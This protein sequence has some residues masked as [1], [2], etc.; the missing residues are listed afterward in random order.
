LTPRVDADACPAAVEQIV[1]CA[2]N[3]RE[4]RAV[5]VANEHVAVP[6][7]TWVSTVRVAADLDIA[8]GHIVRSAS[9]RDLAVTADVP[10]AAAL[11]A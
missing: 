4:P 3:R 7:S 1:V 11:A 5:F 8:D 2:A 10:L 6:R 9:A